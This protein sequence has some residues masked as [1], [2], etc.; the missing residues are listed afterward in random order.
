[1]KKKFKFLV[2]K[3]I[4]LDKKPSKKDVAIIN[5]IWGDFIEVEGDLQCFLNYAINGHTFKADLCDRN[6]SNYRGT[7]CFIIDIDN[8][9]L[10]K[11]YDD[12]LN[13][14]INKTRVKTLEEG[15]LT[16]TG[17]IEL[18]NGIGQFNYG[19]YNTFSNTKE[20]NR[21]RIIVILDE[22]IFDREKR[23]SLYKAFSEIF[24]DDRSSSNYNKLFFGTRDDNFHLIKNKNY[25]K[26]E[27]LAPFIQNSTSKTACKASINAPLK[28]INTNTPPIL[29]PI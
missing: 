22:P 11:E 12:A 27:D 19:I 7:Y 8:T 26:E 23:D 3:N 9:Y 6:S 10:Y 2:T 13:K 17:A 4:T 1:M 29:S 28:V 16:P 21:F 25:L 24:K 14:E 20:W 15:Y 18:L 5:K